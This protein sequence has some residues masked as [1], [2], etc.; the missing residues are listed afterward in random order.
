MSVTDKF[1]DYVSLD[2]QSD[3]T[4]TTAPSTKKQLVLARKLEEELKQIGVSKRG[5]F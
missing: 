4:S 2:T 3:E 5:T 1:L